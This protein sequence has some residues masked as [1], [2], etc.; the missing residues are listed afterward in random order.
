MHTDNCCCDV[1]VDFTAIAMDAGVEAVDI[2]A[3]AVDANALAIDTNAMAIDVTAEATLILAGSAHTDP[4]NL[5]FHNDSFTASL[6]V[7]LLQEQ[8]YTASFCP[9][10]ALQRGT[11]FPELIG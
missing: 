7:T 4:C 9:C 11:L 1:A 3:E 5:F 2:A 6:P 10:D 8:V